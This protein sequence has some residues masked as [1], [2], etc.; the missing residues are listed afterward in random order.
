M[1]KLNVIQIG[2]KHDHSRPTFQSAKELPDYEV[3]GWY[4]PDEAFRE[5][6][7]SWWEFADSHEFT[8]LDE[9]WAAPDLDAVII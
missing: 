7:R 1:K 4:E 6:S 8:S 2:T 9:V 3:L 5:T